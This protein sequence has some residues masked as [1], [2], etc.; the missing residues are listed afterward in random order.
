MS[1]SP[2]SFKL[3]EKK[4]QILVPISF[5]LEYIQSLITEVVEHC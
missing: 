2:D 1:S 5:I 3:L 4:I